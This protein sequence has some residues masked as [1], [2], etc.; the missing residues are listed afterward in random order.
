MII[1][2]IISFFAHRNK[3][4]Y[5]LPKLSAFQISFPNFG[6]V[7]S[8]VQRC[9]G[10]GSARAV[11][12]YPMVSGYRPIPIEISKI[13]VPLG[14]GQKKNFGY[15]WVLGTGQKKK[16]WYRWVPG[17]GPKKN[18]GYRVLARKKILGIDGYR[19]PARRKI[20]GN[21]GYWV[22]GKF[23]LMPTPGCGIKKYRMFKFGRLIVLL[24]FAQYGLTN[25]FYFPL[26]QL[27]ANLNLN[28]TRIQGVSPRTPP[29]PYGTSLTKPDLTYLKI[30]RKG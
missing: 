20:L 22:L 12:R 6:L 25:S 8:L 13:W 28:R 11:P 1:L 9:C 23:S 26:Q 16:F 4:K 19:V 29:P 24:Y 30:Y 15:R 2:K 14:T 5:S 10:H 21:D 3:K 27:E 18:F 7:V 17:T